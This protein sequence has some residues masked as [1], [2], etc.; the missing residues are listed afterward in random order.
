MREGVSVTAYIRKHTVTRGDW[1][2]VGPQGTA[3]GN[4]AYN[5]ER[6]LMYASPKGRAHFKVVIR[7]LYYLH[8]VVSGSSEAGVTRLG[9]TPRW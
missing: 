5:L 8:K 4:T 3:S 6:R 7:E 9:V 1:A 2:E